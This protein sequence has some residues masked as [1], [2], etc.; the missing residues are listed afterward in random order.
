MTR[1]QPVLFIGLDGAEPTQLARWMA[2][3][4]LPV[5]AKLASEGC[6]GPV[7]T[8]P[9]MGD[10]ATWP[11]LVTSCSPARHGRYFRSQQRSSSY[12][13]YN[14][15]TDRDLKAAPFWEQLDAAG[16]KVA[17]LDLPYTPRTS[18]AHGR[19][20]ADWCIHD[21]YGPPRSHPPE[22]I[23]EIL[24]TFGDDPIGGCSDHVD[25]SANGIRWLQEQLVNRVSQKASYVCRTLGEQRWDLLC[26]GFAEMHDIGHM[27]WHMHDPVSPDHDA[28]FV[29][30]NGDPWLN[31]AQATDR[32]IGRIVEAAPDGTRIVLFAGLGMGPD[33]TANELVAPILS[34]LDGRI[35]DWQPGVSGWVRR[36]T[37]NSIA[38]RI[39][40]KFD[41]L[42]MQKQRQ[43]ARFYELGHNENSGAIRINLKGREP[44]GRVEAIDYDAVCADLSQAFMELR[45]PENGLP[46]VSQVIKVRDEPD[47]AGP[48][49][50]SLPDL[51]VV[52]NREA[53][54]HAVESPRVGRLEGAR[55]WG[56]TGDH[57]ANAWL[58]VH[59]AALG[60]GRL[61]MVPRV[62]DIGATL[63]SLVGVE[64]SGV[65]G[66]PI[67]GLVKA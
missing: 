11:S 13:S 15:E 48:L 56:R 52:W 1:S 4:K 9:G 58:L 46:I 44:A 55:S 26:A 62:V 20:I 10:G 35:G 45:N 16:R 49:Q 30:A 31:V 39:A 36:M 51:F 17:I 25:K 2:E 40:G 61:P 3:G 64:L 21:R 6:V 22:L 34:R 66:V 54:F 67:P 47:Y 12:A 18:L 59:G 29:A 41:W 65:D 63:A 27:G 14:F 7:R 8:L 5:L 37:R 23:D 43:I 50:D 28:V 53:P 60:P 19:V 42:V 32:A 57:T 33:Y 38:L 24:S